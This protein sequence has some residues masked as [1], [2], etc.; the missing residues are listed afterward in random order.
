MAK[1]PLTVKK[2]EI[3][4]SFDA[5]A[6][7]EVAVAGDF[8]GWDFKKHPL[9]KDKDGTWKAIVM[10]PPGDYGYKY[11]V[12]GEWRNDPANSEVSVNS[13]GTHNNVL[14]VSGK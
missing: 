10:L 4:F 11:Y 1:K 3:V 13:F 8:N 6:A 12:D 5:P 2:K 14:K 9:K 7:K